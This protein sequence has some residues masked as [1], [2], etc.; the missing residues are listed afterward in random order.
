MKRLVLA[1]AFLAAAPSAT[2][3]G[4][5]TEWA[6]YR[7]DGEAPWRFARAVEAAGYRVVLSTPDG[8]ALEARVVVDASPFG[9]D[10]PFPPPLDALGPEARATLAEP[11][12]EDALL[13]AA[14]SRLLAGALTTLEAVERV[15]AFTSRNVAYKLPD[16]N[17]TAASA[18]SSGRGSCVGR[19]LLAADLLLRAGVPVRQVTGL[20]VAAEP[21]ELTPESRLVYNAGLGG[22]RHRWIEVFVPGLGWVPSDPGGLANTV[23]AR[24]LALSR[25]PASSFHAGV[26]SRSAEIRRPVLEGGE[27]RITLARPRGPLEGAPFDPAP[28]AAPRPAGR[29]DRR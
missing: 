22:V 20:L 8:R 17:E 28:L 24:H 21:W 1:L 14:S 29:D 7:V 19:S 5:R 3:E 10:A 4:P 9:A 25:Q 12:P 13:E 16:G 26:L 11:R 2:A 27:G 18:L 6:Q 23:T 15:I